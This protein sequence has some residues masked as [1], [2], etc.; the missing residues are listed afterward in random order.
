MNE[1]VK[2]WKEKLT[3]E[4]MAVLALLGLLFMVIALPTG[5]GKGKGAGEEIR[6]GQ[7]V[8][9]TESGEGADIPPE[10]AGQ[11]YAEDMERR[12]EELL[13]CMDGVG[14]VKVMVT[15]SASEEKVVEKDV[16]SSAESIL[17]TDSAG[18]TRESVSNTQEEGTVYIT[19]ASGSR[20]PYVKKT[21]EPS[22]EGVT[23]VAQGGGNPV[24]QK[25]V[26]EVIEALFDV[27]AHKIRVVK[28]K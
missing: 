12:L 1:R 28:M 3:K 27:D 9:E 15:M 14:Q 23:V 19:D 20:T 21:L 18:G 13:S 25:S 24:I 2:R 6:S 8:S 17:E 7:S 22:V 10:T 26:T 16:P 5:G 11:A 4:N